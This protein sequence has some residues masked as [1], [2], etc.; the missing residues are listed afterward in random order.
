MRKAIVLSVTLAMLFGISSM[1]RAE[2]RSGAFY[3]TPQIGGYVFEGNQD[4]DHSP[5][6]GLGLGYLLDPHWAAELTFNYIDAEFES[7]DGDVDG[8]L[9]RL[10]GLYHFM[11]ENRL[12]PYLAAGIGGIR[13]EP[14]SGSSD[15]SF[16][17]NAGGGLKY[18]LT[19]SIA[20]RGDARYVNTFDDSYS[21]LIYTLS[22]DF[23]FGG[24]KKAVAAAAPID[25][26]GDGVTDDLDQCPGTPAGVAV[27]ADG[28]PPDSDGDGVY[29]YQDRCPGTPAGAA[30]DSDGCPLDSDGDGVYDYQDRC[31]DTPAGAAVDSD[32][33]PLDS[34]GDGVY[35]YQDQCPDTPKDL[36]VDEDGCPIMQEQ[37][38][39]MR[40]DIQFDLNKAEVKPQYHQQL[41]KVADFLTTYPKTHAVIEGHSDNTGDADYNKDL[42]QR[43]AASV[44]VYLIEKFDIAPD[45][46]TAVGYG[47]ERPVASNDTSQGRAQNRRVVAVIS[48][49]TQTYQK[50]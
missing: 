37:Q 44:R 25:S 17:I 36:K 45:R 21:N 22:L 16:L 47:E 4:L 28:C 49:D 18:F 7:S 48:A 12:V 5:T 35:D 27:D 13:L 30:V 23:L 42:S 32:G 26:D 46:L 33:C 10:D 8:Y 19:E 20:L 3:L 29:D 1:V 38:V 50:K 43:R 41:K 34:D 31:P 9:L 14:D 6:I 15:D 2:L 11:P 40:L 39:S 24:Q